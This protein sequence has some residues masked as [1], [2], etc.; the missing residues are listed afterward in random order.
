M[1]PLS[2]DLGQKDGVILGASNVSQILQNT[3]DDISK[4]PLPEVVVQKIDSF[5]QVH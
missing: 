3:L 4:G 2:F 5:A 1:T